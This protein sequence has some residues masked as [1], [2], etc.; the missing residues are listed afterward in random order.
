MLSKRCQHR[1]RRLLRGLSHRSSIAFEHEIV[2]PSLSIVC[3]EGLAGIESVHHDTHALKIC[4]RRKCCRTP[5]SGLALRVTERLT[6]SWARDWSQV[7]VTPVKEMLQRAAPSKSGID[8]NG[9]VPLKQP[10]ALRF[11]LRGIV[12]HAGTSQRDTMYWAVCH[13]CKMRPCYRH[14]P[15]APFGRESIAFMPSQIFEPTGHSKCRD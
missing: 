3:G 10:V 5:P 7:C 2:V 6:S 8:R 12:T 11:H 9:C 4:A 1:V 15:G 14:M 13:Q